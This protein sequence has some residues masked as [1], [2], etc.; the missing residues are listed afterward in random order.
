MKPDPDAFSGLDPGARILLAFSGGIDSSAAGFL[1]RSAGFDVLPVYL[2]LLPKNGERETRV[3]AVAE[4]LGIGGLEILDLQNEFREEVMRPCW[5]EFER[6]RTPNPCVLCNPLF[7]FG[8][9]QKFAEERGCAVMATGHYVRVSRAAPPQIL[10][11]ADEGKD[12]SYFLYGL[13]D[14]QLVRTCFPL[15]SFHKEEVRRLVRGL[16][17]PNAS[18]PESQDICF[19][20][21]SV[22]TAELLRRLFQA[23]AHPGCF[24]G[25]DGRVL[26]HH[27]GYHVFTPGQRKGTGVALGKPAYVRSVDADT[28]SVVLTTEEKDLMS[29][30]LRVH[31]VRLRHPLPPAEFRCVVQIRYRGKPAEATVLMT[32][33]NTAEV[34]FDHPVRA[35]TPGQAAVFYDGIRQLGGGCIDL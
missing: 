12:Q 8:R 3:R 10:R 16:G 25:T 4:K 23:E 34:H 20:Q 2:R 22:H 11:G 33:S 9:L 6:G 29:D 32:S 26:G 27:S 19:A 30:H 15:G 17:L 35:V 24:L 14:E 18:D 28:A 31:D 7:K 21:D 13:S 5:E 1:C